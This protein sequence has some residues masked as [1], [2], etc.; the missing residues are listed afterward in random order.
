[1]PVIAALGGRRC[2]EFPA[3]MPSAYLDADG[4]RHTAKPDYVIPRDGYTV[5]V[6]GKGSILN[7]HHT[8][9]SS[10]EALKEAYREHFYRPGDNMTH[11]QLSTALFHYSRRGQLSIL[12][13]AFN[14]SRWKQAAVQAVHGWQRFIL[15]FK[16]PPCKYEAKRYIDAG[17]VFATSKTLPDLLLTIEL[18]QKGFLIPFV[19][20][21]RGYSFSVMPDSAS[22]TLS[23]EMVQANDRAKFLAAV[24]ADREAIAAQ[25]AQQEAD[26]AAGILPF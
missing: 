20:K 9:A 23:T 25:K 1:M 16:S 12:R 8:F 4:E 18:S 22:R 14:H 17:I 11:A 13:N 24:A 10:H 15:V 26:E 19:F 3:D 21:A 2:T 7:N 5:V 6:E